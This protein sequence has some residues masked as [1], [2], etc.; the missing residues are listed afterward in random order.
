MLISDC[1][2]SK[3][4]E[5]HNSLPH[6]PPPAPQ[7]PTKS[8]PHISNCSAASVRPSITKGAVRV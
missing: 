5:G 1:I 3:K 6:P 4:I 7:P 2:L 8:D